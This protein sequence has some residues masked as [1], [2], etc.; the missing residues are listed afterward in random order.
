M[1]SEGVLLWPWRLRQGAVVSATPGHNF[2]GR[3]ETT[4]PSADEAREGGGAKSSMKG[5]AKRSGGGNPFFL[6][7]DLH[8]ST[9]R[10]DII[11]VLVQASA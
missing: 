6:P 5:R 4:P 3:V 11:A 10:C 7:R 8:M 1:R 2:Q 9:S